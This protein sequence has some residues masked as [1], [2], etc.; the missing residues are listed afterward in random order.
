MVCIQKGDLDLRAEDLAILYYHP[1]LPSAPPPT[2]QLGKRGAIKQLGI[3]SA[4]DLEGHREMVCRHVFFLHL[5]IPLFHRFLMGALQR[6]FQTI[7][8]ITKYSK[9]PKYPTV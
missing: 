9:I 3:D 4:H 6:R 1:H 5:K 2:P 8:A 7:F